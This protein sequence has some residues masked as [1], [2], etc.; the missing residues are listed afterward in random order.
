[1]SIM[2]KILISLFLVA[3]GLCSYAASW[4]RINDKV[5]LDT[6]G[7]MSSGKTGSVYSFWTKELNDGDA[8]FIL[9]ERTYSQKIWYDLVH[10]S[11]DCSARKFKIEEVLIYGLNNNFIG[12]DT[13]ALMGWNSI[14]PQSVAEDYLELVCKYQPKQVNN[15]PQKQEQTVKNNNSSSALSFTEFDPNAPVAKANEAQPTKTVDPAEIDNY[16]KKLQTK[17]S[18]NWQRPNVDGTLKFSLVF[19]ISKDGTLVTLSEFKTSGNKDF[20][21]SASEA[22][23]KSVPFDEI[24]SG[25]QHKNIDVQVTFGEGVKVFILTSK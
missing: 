21:N 7:I 16:M 15:E 18:S 4:E 20:D 22:V 25:F 2:K 12:K 5:Y 9:A 6:S 10:Y 24:P 3:L 1:M 8:D 23:K 14:P 11:I 19:S 13:S 17:I